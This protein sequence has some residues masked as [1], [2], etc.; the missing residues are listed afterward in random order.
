MAYFTQPSNSEDKT[1]LNQLARLLKDMI[2]GHKNTSFKSYLE[3]L[4][5]NT[6]AE[7]SL[8]KTTRKIRRQTRPLRPIRKGDGT[9]ARSY[10]DT[11]ATFANYLEST[12]RLEDENSSE[13]LHQF[14]SGSQ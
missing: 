3:G 9:W 5:S 2:R 6:E 7:Y 1:M 4:Q 12:F 13:V 11:A 8:W 14:T 10:E